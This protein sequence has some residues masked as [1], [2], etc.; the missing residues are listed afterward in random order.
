MFFASSIFYR[1][2]QNASSFDLEITLEERNSI[3]ILEYEGK[4]SCGKLVM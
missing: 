2:R 4:T 1:S 3:S